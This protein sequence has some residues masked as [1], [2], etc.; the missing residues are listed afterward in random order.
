MRKAIV[1]IIAVHVPIAG[2]TLVPFLFGLPL[3]LTPL[4]IA[5][6]EMIIDPACSL[7]LEAEEEERDVMSRPPHDPR[8]NIITRPLILWGVLQ[9][10]LALVAVGVVMGTA[11]VMKLP[12]DEIRS[13]SFVLLICCN[14]ALILANR[15]FSS[16]VLMAFFRP[17]AILAWGGSGT[18][19]LLAFLLSW[20]PAAKL[21]K[22]GP[23]HGHDLLICL[24]GSGL[25]LMLLEIFKR[26]VAARLKA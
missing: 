16:S 6:M 26:R 12:E 7:V 19:A 23:F 1:Y 22:F 8:V 21:F 14:L 24:S 5:L 4:L 25:L 2:L 10:F 17:N 11:V 20:A 18:A 15:S 13:L 3:I 9:G